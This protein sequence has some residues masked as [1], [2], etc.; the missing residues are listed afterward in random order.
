MFRFEQAVLHRGE[1]RRGPAGLEITTPDEQWSYAVSIPAEWVTDTP[2]HPAP[3]G[4]IRL[5]FAS[6]DGEVSV[7]ALAAAETVLDQALLGPSDV[8]AEVE[9]IC[10]PLEA[11]QS[12]VIRNAR[13]GGEPSRAVLDSIECVHVDP[14]TDEGDVEADS[15]WSPVNDWPDYYRGRHRS[16]AERIRGLRYAQFSSVKHMSWLDGLTVHIWPNDDLSRVLYVSGAYEPNTMIVMRRWLAPG[17]IFLDVGAN[18]GMFSMVAARLVGKDGRVYAFEPSDRERQ[19]LV[20]NL[21]LN[22]LQNVTVLPEAVADRQTSVQLR[23]GKFP[24]AGQNTTAATFAYPEVAIE[25][26]ETVDAITLDDFVS[27]NGLRRIDVIKLDIEGGEY[28]ALAGAACV[29]AQFRPRLILELSPEACGSHGVS[30]AALAARVQAAG[31]R[32]YRVGSEAQLVPF[33]AG[34]DNDESNVIAVPIEQVLP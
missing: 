6:V 30:T 33:D 32:L 13:L 21:T 24:N 12:V 23:V 34:E 7:L 14:S 31:Y 19:R 5:R 27:T 10:I 1:M 18:V 15:A 3:D 28:A 2:Q 4:I 17:G 9:L 16:L 8:P 11:C 25:R 29:L 26:I 22:A 20:A